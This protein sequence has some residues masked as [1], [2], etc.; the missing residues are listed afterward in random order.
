MTDIRIDTTLSS[1]PPDEPIL[2]ARG[3]CKQYGRSHAL[4]DLD[5]TLHVGEVLG[6]IG[7]NGA[8]KSTL[9]KLLTG[10]EQPDSGTIRLRGRPATVR[11]VVDAGRQGIGIVFQ[12]QSLILNLTVAENILL[13]RK[14]T[15]TR[16]GFYNWGRMRAETQR[17]LEIAGSSAKPTDL[18]ETLSFVDR[19]SVELAKV[20]AL[21]D[22]VE[23]ALVILFDEP[24]SVLS[25]AEIQGLFAQIN[26]LKARAA[27][28]FVSHRMDEVLTISDRVMVL[29]DGQLVSEH[30]AGDVAADDLHR[31]MVGTQRSEDYYVQQQRPDRSEA[32][33]LLAATALDE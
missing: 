32:P 9:L 31:L 11:S 10:V 29:R 12:E 13:G 26:R 16:G 8:G 3:L 17:Y 21:E 23:G 25:A 5:L 24:T 18:V 6:L 4:K 14:S 2:V 33:I 20:L 22:R 15:S 30:H 27:M 19:Q 7:Q 28:I 1:S